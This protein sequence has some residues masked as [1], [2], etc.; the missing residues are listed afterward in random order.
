MLYRQIAVARFIQLAAL[1]RIKNLPHA[2]LCHLE[3]ITPRYNSARPPTRPPETEIPNV[4][5][6]KPFTSGLLPIVGRQAEAVDDD[7]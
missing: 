5:S 7:M 4:N 2:R 6:M 1:Q 3:K